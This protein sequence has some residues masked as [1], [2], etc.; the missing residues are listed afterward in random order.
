MSTMKKS[1]RSEQVTIFKTVGN[2]NLNNKYN[3]L[4]LALVT[5]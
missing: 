3:N 4:R 1:N 5:D 2:A